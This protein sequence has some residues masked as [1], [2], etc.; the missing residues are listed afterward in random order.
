MSYYFSKQLVWTFVIFSEIM[1]GISIQ[2]TQNYES[3][4]GW[5]ERILQVKL[6][7][8]KTVNSYKED[9]QRKGFFSEWIYIEGHF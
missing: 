9:H 7:L 4:M 8:S 1:D 3:L 6:F 2:V 5:S